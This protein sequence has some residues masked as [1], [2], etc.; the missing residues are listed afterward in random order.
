MGAL[1]V[2]QPA[3]IDT[4]G[5]LRFTLPPMQGRLHTAAGEHAA[6]ACFITPH[7][8][9]HAARAAAILQAVYQQVGNCRF[10]LYTTVPDWFFSES[11]AGPFFLDAMETDIGLVQKT[12]LVEDLTATAQGLDRWYPL[13]TGLVARVADTL[14]RRQTRLVICDIAPLGIAVARSAGIPSVLVENFTWDWI[15]R[16]YPDFQQRLGRHMDYLSG[17]FE[18]ADAR[19][20]AR[21]ICGDAV[22][23]LTVDPVSRSPRLSRQAVRQ[24]LGVTPEETLVLVSLGGTPLG[25]GLLGLGP[26]PSG[27]RIVVPANGAVPAEHPGLQV[28]AHDAVYHPD[29][30]GA[31]DAVIG[32]TGYS[33]LAEVFHAGVPFGYVS[34]GRFPESAVLEAFARDAMGAWPLTEA[35]LKSGSWIEAIPALAASRRVSVAL[36][37][38]ADAAARFIVSLLPS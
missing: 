18:Q 9:G 6:I 21:P 7:G 19:I 11:L 16:G 32:K 33:T 26:I 24:G 3:V 2:V 27:I 30:I 34:R 17:L 29:L 5:V 38:G 1:F 37:N 10:D 36:P 35:D 23:H 13:D 8:Y 28:V 20:R 25:E 14:V 31:C 15:Y 22:G 12:P 4:V